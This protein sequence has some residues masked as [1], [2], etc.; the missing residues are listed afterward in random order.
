MLRAGVIVR[1]VGPNQLRI[2]VGTAAQNRRCMAALQAA[3]A[4]PVEV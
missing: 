1:P 4:A 3:L 2:T